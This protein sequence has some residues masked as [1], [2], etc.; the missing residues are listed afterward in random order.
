MGPDGGDVRIRFADF[1]A[2]LST[3]ELFHH[4]KRVRLQR[5][6]FQILESLLRAAGVLVPREQLYDSVWPGVHVDRQRCLNVEIGR[7][8]V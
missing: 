7:A 8:H 2:D 3:G 1:E 5:K 4:G 6:P